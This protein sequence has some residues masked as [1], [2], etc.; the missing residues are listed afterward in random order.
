MAVTAMVCGATDNRR[1]SYVRTLF[2]LYQKY[3]NL[4]PIQIAII[5]YLCLLKN[6]F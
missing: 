2:K 4:K 1:F 6:A 3:T 5:S